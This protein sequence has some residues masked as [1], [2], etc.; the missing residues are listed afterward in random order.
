MPGSIDNQNAVTHGMYSFIQRGED[1]L[2]PEKRSRYQELREQFES[3]PGRL[4]YRKQLAAFLAQVCE[5]GFDRLRVDTESGKDIWTTPG[6]LKMLGVYVNSLT[7]L[8]DSWPK[9]NGKK[10]VIDLLK[11]GD[12]GKD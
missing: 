9:E 4:D 10:N 6:P 7:R 5:I 2:P 3:E 12:D 1:A 11:G 8:L